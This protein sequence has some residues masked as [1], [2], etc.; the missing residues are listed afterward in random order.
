MGLPLGT[1]S[2]G[3]RVPLLASFS[4][5]RVG[6]SILASLSEAGG[7]DLQKVTSKPLPPRL[8]LYTSRHLKRAYVVPLCTESANAA[9]LLA[10][11]KWPLIFTLRFRGPTA[12]CPKSVLPVQFGTL[13]NLNWAAASFPSH[14]LS[15]RAS[16]RTRVTVLPGLRSYRFFRAFSLECIHAMGFFQR[17]STPAFFSQI[18]LRG[19]GS[20]GELDATVRG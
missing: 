18:A 17:R 12:C 13:S 9:F 2:P 7:N 3:R 11:H 8:S 20:P 14:W 6:S 10:P 5:Q 15:V 19:H 1:G 4:H 16:S